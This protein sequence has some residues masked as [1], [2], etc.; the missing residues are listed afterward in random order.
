MGNPLIS[1]VTGTYN[2]LS[3]LQRMIASVR[4]QLPR[5]I[6]YELVL[7]DGGSTDGTIQWCE[8]Q[9]DVKLIRHGEL[10]G[11][12]KAFC[13]GA[14]AASGDYVCLANDDVEFHPGSLLSAVAHLE[15]YRTCG[16]VAFADNRYSQ[17]VDPS[18]G[19]M[20]MPMSAIGADGIP[21]AVNYAQVGMFRA[22]LG[23]LV[24]WWGDQDAIMGKART[25]GG[26]NYL[27]ARI[28]E[29]GYSVDAVEACRVDDHIPRDALRQSNTNAGSQDS[30]QYYARYPRGPQVQAYPQTPNP[31][32]E[33]LRIV[34]MDIHEPRM[35]ARAAKEEG[36]AEALAK[37][38]LLWHIDYVNEPCDLPLVVDGWQPHLLITQAHEVGTINAD[39]LEA[40]RRQKPDMVI[41]NWC[42]DAHERCLIDPDVMEMLR[43]VDLQTTINAKVLPQYERSGIPAA[44]WQIGYKA[45]AAPYEGEVPLHE[46][47][48]QGNC[49]NAERKALI[50]ALRSIRINKH[51]PDIGIYGSCEGATG[52]THYDFAH[53]AALNANAVI[54]IGDTY[55]NT[56]AFVSNRLF[57]V[58][59]AGGFLLQQHSK[60]L[61]RYT[62]LIAGVH[63]VE[64]TDLTDL[65]AKVK[66]W[67]KPEQEAARQQIA[68]AG[69]T[70]VQ[71]NFSYDAQVQKLWGLLDAVA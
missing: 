29:L 41:V 3:S 66:H 68:E 65:V 38:G 60:N 9:P 33:R 5:H 42:G 19:H 36:L 40:A 57:Q 10:K 48:F 71:A 39:V 30:A 26:D 6:S 24:G 37:V 58:L 7:V 2:R 35:P 59:G 61:D 44:Y 54:V 46:V 49:Y 63:Y 64:W 4:K 12:I 47:L 32:R 16:A 34:L 11:A 62:G 69:Q 28:W 20:V 52:N 18:V 17:V 22:W 8:A 23:N 21:R 55:P 45:P 53:Q 67:L 27:S 43:H 70:F 1:I 15:D 51:R 13:E 25:Y 14:R 31:Q 56:E 50:G